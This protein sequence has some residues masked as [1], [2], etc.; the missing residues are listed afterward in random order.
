MDNEIK[1]VN[2]FTIHKLAEEDRILLKQRAKEKRE[3]WFTIEPIFK[4]VSK[5]EF[6]T[7][8][9]NYPRK[10]DRDVCGICD[11]PAISYNDFELANRWPWSIVAS[12][13]LYSDDPDDYWYESP[14]NRNYRI[15]INYNELF[16][17][18]T[19]YKEEN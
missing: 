19:G 4:N 10:L 17:A 9:K 12:T 18:R 16:E 2:I 13:M 11:P 1:E 5:E 15:L 7:F 6:D 14:E 8:I 3:I